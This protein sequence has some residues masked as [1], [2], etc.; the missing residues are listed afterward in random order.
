MTDQVF[1][2]KVDAWLAIVLG[3]VVVLYVAIGIAMLVFVPKVGVVIGIILMF[4]AAFVASTLA[5]TDYTFT[6]GVLL[7]RCGPIRWRIPIGS[8][9]DAA[10]TRSPFS[11]P[12]LSMDRVQLSYAGG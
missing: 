9:S 5:W 8:I 7:I 11:G 3:F 4:A 12:A 2:S 6:E 10:P 1:K